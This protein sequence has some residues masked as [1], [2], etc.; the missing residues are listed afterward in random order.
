MIVAVFVIRV[1]AKSRPFP[2]TVLASELPLGTSEAF[3][4]FMLVHPSK[5]VPPPSVPLRKI[6]FV[7]IFMSP[8]DQLLLHLDFIYYLV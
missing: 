7:V 1:F 4:L 5:T 8:E 3:L 6:Q 2:R